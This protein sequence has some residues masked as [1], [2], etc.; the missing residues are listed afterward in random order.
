MAA[1]YVGGQPGSR[2][3]DFPRAVVRVTL[4]RPV[5]DDVLYSIGVLSWPR[6]IETI[7]ERAQQP[8]AW[9]VLSGAPRETNADRTAVID[10]IIAAAPGPE[11]LAD[12]VRAIDESA[13]WGVERATVARIEVVGRVPGFNDGGPAAIEQGRAAEVERSAAEAG[14]A[15]GDIAESAR[16]VL[17]SVSGTVWGLAA[18]GV[19]GLV[20]YSKLRR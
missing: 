2:L 5:L 4:Q 8:G 11:T 14:S 7:M 18:L 6:T 12:M 9:T 10:F 20:I 13:R 17:G 16:R 19:V 3:G 15:L 1:V